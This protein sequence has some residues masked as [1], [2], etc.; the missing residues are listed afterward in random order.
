M[1]GG[2][3]GGP[4]SIL[5]SESISGRRGGSMHPT[6]MPTAHST[7]WVLNACK[8]KIQLEDKPEGQKYHLSL[9]P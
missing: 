2:R 3:A 9:S 7:C 5:M 4:N 6:P 1:L 8:S